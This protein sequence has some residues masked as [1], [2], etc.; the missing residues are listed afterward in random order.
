MTPTSLRRLVSALWQARMPLSALLWRQMLFLG[1]MLNLLCSLGALA[2]MA[3]GVDAIWA[4][5][6]HFAPLPW[7]ALLVSAVWRHPQST[8]GWS[9]VA[10]AWFMAMLVI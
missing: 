1:S 4:V 5:A 8:P 7:N 6:L 9:L 10:L 2:L 3:A